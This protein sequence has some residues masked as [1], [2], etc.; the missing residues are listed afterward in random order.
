MTATA[1][2]ATANAALIS[3]RNQYLDTFQKEIAT[4]LTVLR[5][6]PEDKETLQ[7][8]PKLRTA[9]DL[10]F[11]FVQEMGM[12]MV[13]LT[14]GFDWSQP[15]QMPAAPPTLAQVISSLDEMQKQLVGIVSGYTDERLVTEKVQFPSGKG[16]MGEM[17]KIQFLWMMLCDQIHHRGQF[18]VYL[19]LA[20]ARVPSIYGPTADDPWF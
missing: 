12:G 18:S 16:Q 7:P 9:R 19:R 6:F 13:A 15:P 5:A 4:T 3:P 1:T 14:S 20:G 17:S 10:A 8:S 2:P 11:V